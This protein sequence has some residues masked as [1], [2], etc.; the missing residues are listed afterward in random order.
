[1]KNVLTLIASDGLNDSMVMRVQSALMDL[2][3]DTA[4]PV[5][6]SSERAVDLP[7]EK[8]SP[9]EA[10]TVARQVLPAS[11]DVIAQAKENR[12]KKLLVADMDS[13]MV[14]GETLDELADFAGIKAHI[15]AITARA[16]NG[17]ID[18]KTA[19]RERV[20]LL[21][22]LSA[23]ALDLTYQRISFTPGG[24]QFIAT[25]KAH[26]AY[27]ILVSG[28]FSFFTERVR[29]H[30]G[31][32]RDLSNRMEIIDGHLTGRVLDPIL[33]RSSKLHTLLT[34]AAEKK[35]SIDMTLAVGDG[36]N[37]LEM[38]KAAGMG[39]AFHAKPIVAAE[40]RI[41]IDHGDLFAVLYAQGYHDEEIT[42]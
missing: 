23:E 36:A 21:K 31:F 40:A 7:F 12:R 29:E 25:M 30:L 5:W 28:G 24:K 13:T 26:G 1:M 17:E 3:A 35:L 11:I 39:V 19:V 41:R 42:G 8:L 32:D 4:A 16:M 6:L 2:G 9:V 20:G 34:S 18:F 15:A 27:T 33:D 14:T 22:G 38:I 37:D 10:D